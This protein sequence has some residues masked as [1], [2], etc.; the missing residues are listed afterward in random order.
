MTNDAE[1]LA[2]ALLLLRGVDYFLVLSLPFFAAAAAALRTR[3]R[4]PASLV[5]FGLAGIA[6]A[7]Y[8]AFWLW[9]FSPRTGYWFSL[10]LPLACGGYLA[11]SWRKF[12]HRERAAFRAISK[13]WTLSLAAALLILAAGFLFG[14]WATPLTT[15]QARFSHALPPDNALPLIFADQL[16]QGK[17]LRP[18]AGEWHSSDRPPLQT[19]FTLLADPYRAGPRTLG[20]MILA[21]FLQSLWIPAAWALFKTLQVSGRITA[22]LIAGVLFSGFVFVNSFFVWP[23]LLSAAYAIACLAALFASEPAAAIG[24]VL[25]AFSL[26]A[27][28]GSVFALLGAAAALVLL[29]K[30]VTI[31]TALTILAALS[32]SYAPWFAYQK[33][34][35]PPGDRLL[36]MHLAGDESD[37][38]PLGIAL[39]DAYGRLTVRQMMAARVQNAKTAFGYEA[40]YWRNWL[41]AH[42]QRTWQFFYFFPALGIYMLGPLALAAGFARKCRTS[43]WRIAALCWIFVLCTLVVWCALLFTP[44]AAVIHQGAYAAVVLAVAGSV[45]A[46][47]NVSRRLAQILITLQSAAA[48]LIYVVLAPGEVHSAMLLLLIGALCLLAWT[49]RW[50]AREREVQ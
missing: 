46:L 3:F 30:R 15:A 40:E 9:F 23:K 24:G 22:W 21:V 7:A 41:S 50:M 25:G 1:F 35:D 17:V 10:M 16:R 33:L 38:R 28:G 19:G 6:L 34:Y 26:L 47:W 13:P 36:K 12:E 43:L 42:E 29:R 39:K 8:A 20:Y 18:M 31:R 32:L 27:H 48:F 11:W 2:A 37:P 4:Q 45:L 44:R 49:L 14:G 5:L